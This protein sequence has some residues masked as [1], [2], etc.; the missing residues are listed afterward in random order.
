MASNNVKRE[1]WGRKRL[2]A[3][4]IH[5]HQKLFH[6]QLRGPFKHDVTQWAGGER[7]WMGNRHEKHENAQ[8]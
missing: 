5:R 7:K 6:V 2:D 4:S 8:E 1:I 3:A